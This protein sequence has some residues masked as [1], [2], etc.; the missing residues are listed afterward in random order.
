MHQID[1]CSAAH[2]SDELCHFTPHEYVNFVAN[3][4]PRFRFDDMAEV[5]GGDQGLLGTF[6]LKD[7]ASIAASAWTED[8][9]ERQVRC[10]PPTHIITVLN[11]VV[12]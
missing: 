1:R 5:R 10:E 7:C 11:G 2:K 12:K 8:H 9:R 6:S 3:S 4:L